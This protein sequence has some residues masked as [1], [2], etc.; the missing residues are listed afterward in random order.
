MTDKKKKILIV[1][2]DQF[3]LKLY[4]HLLTE[5]GFETIVTP[6]ASDALRLAK[7]NKPDLFLVDIML[8][9]G[10]GFA[11]IKEIRN[12][13]GFKKTPII[14]L[15]NLGQEADIV[16]A[17]KRGADKYFVKSNT[18]FQELTDMVKKMIK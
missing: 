4:S 12:T 15:S 14:V 16:E 6:L 18:R 2:D 11:I 8:Q 9:D 10:N 13:A 7:E 5:E 1:E 17:I 3:S